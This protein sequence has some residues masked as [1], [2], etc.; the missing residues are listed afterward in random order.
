MR[1]KT[2]AVIIIG[3]EILTGK[4]EDKNASFLIRELHS[5]GV[6]LRRIAV[7]P[8]DV[9][10]IAET[11]AACVAKV[12][13]VFTSGGM[14][15]THDDVT[16]EGV[17]KAFGRSIVR[18]PG[19]V[20]VIHGYFGSS[21]DDA[22]LRMADAPEGSELIYSAMTSWPVLATE[23]VYILPGVPEVFR[24][25]FEAIRERFRTTPF[26]T[27][28]VFTRE[29]EFDL[30]PR[31]NQVAAMSPGVAIGS[32][33]NFESGDYRVKVT[34][35]AHEVEAVERAKALL[36]KLLNPACVVRTG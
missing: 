25:K 30:A 35:E 16:I 1:Q 32:Y 7:I 17:A 36:I 33:P 4:T 10:A 20:A 3:D 24:A 19:L 21:M 12:D 28:E 13:H 8:D 9:D 23:N 5:L 2:A 11:V 14:G 27:V 31:L 34:V 26:H 18:H 22:R 29:D 6:A 15:P